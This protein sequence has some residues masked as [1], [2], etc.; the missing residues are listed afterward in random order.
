MVT[1]SLIV[2]GLILGSF[3]GSFLN[4]CAHRLARFESIVL[5]PSHCYSCGTQIAWHDNIPLVSY[6]VLRGRCRWCGTS[7]SARYLVVEL[8]TGLLTA[9]ILVLAARNYQATGQSH[10]SLATHWFGMSNH[11]FVLAANLHPGLNALF[12]QHPW[13]KALPW[14]IPIITLLTLTYY[15]VVATITDL[16]FLIIPDEICKACSCSCPGWRRSPA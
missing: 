12:M 13:L 15:L 3:I 14:I 10:G 9:L 7:F 8:V 4:V 6:L 5:P 11:L 2:I 1:V 16:Q